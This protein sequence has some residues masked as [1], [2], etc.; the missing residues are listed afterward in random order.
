MIDEAKAHAIAAAAQTL[1]RGLLV[2]LAYLIN[3]NPRGP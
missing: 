3:P 1:V 2:W